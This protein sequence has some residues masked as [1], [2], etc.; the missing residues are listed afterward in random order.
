MQSPVLDVL[1]MLPRENELTETIT[2]FQWN[3]AANSYELLPVLFKDVGTPLTSVVTGLIMI[4][5][6][7]SFLS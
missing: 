2:L 4:F 1:M 7:Y 6:S 5:G 3:Q